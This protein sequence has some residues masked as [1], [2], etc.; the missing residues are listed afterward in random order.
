MVYF[1]LM[2]VSLQMV[3]IIKYV[4]SFAEG[5]SLQRCMGIWVPAAALCVPAEP[6][7]SL[8]VGASS[9]PEGPHWQLYGSPLTE[10]EQDPSLPGTYQGD[11]GGPGVAWTVC[12]SPHRHPSE[13]SSRLVWACYG[14]W[15]K[16]NRSHFDVMFSLGYM[17]IITYK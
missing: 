10:N 17:V 6:W 3:C 12:C 8:G 2:A 11:L 13:K 4:K 1:Q 14:G 16:G 9:G 7:G 5:D 15:D